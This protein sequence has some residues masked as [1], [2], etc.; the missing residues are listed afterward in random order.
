MV[1]RQ[2]SRKE[3]ENNDDYEFILVLLDVSEIELSKGKYYFDD[4]GK[5]F[6][7]EELLERI[8]N[9]RYGLKKLII[10]AIIKSNP[11]WLPE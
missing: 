7:R 6:N 10:K 1:E 3:I 11:N 8:K 9:L 5:F 4:R 2:S